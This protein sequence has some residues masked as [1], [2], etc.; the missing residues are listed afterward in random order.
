M[1]SMNF[2]A[3]LTAIIYFGIIFGG[4]IFAYK[5]IKTSLNLKKEHNELLKEIIEKL[6]KNN[7][8]V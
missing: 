1:D 2:M 5:S 6:D 4:L 7:Q 3:G 8:K